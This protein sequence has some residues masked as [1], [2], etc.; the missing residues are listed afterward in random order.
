M[1]N[2]EAFQNLDR[3][4][5]LPFANLLSQ[6]QIRP[7]IPLAIG[8]KVKSFKIDPRHLSGVKINDYEAVIK[9]ANFASLDSFI[10]D[11]DRSQLSEF[12]LYSFIFQGSLATVTRFWW[13]WFLSSTKQI[14]LLVLLI[15]FQSSSQANNLLER[16][17]IYT[18]LDSRNIATLPE[19][20]QVY[21]KSS[22]ASPL[23]RAIRQSSQITADSPFYPQAQTDISRWS[24]TI[25][26][27][28]RGRAEDGDLAGAISAASLIPQDN[29]SVELLAQQ[30]T[31]AMQA[32]QE[33]GKEQNLYGDYLAKAK[34]TIDSNQASSYNRAIGILRQI[35]SV[36]EEYPAARSL[37]SQWNREIYAIAKR[38]A[39]LGNFKQAV[40]AATLIPAN[41]IYHQLAKEEINQKIKSIYAGYR[42]S[43]QEI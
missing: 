26:D 2:N 39:D 3:K 33:R 34:A 13:N 4:P 10:F 21:L 42:S 14:S 7:S 12:S 18:E 32:W 17:R 20:S 31:T 19:S 5:I 1:Y 40:E 35:P 41:S 6:N 28:A 36:A 23:N 8:T 27:I 22:Q 16:A 29:P 9:L 15:L 11:R 24:E 43:E 37:I 25:L 38:R 30:A